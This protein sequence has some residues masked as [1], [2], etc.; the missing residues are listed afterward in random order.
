MQLCQFNIAIPVYKNLLL[1]FTKTDTYTMNTI[2]HLQMLNWVI[3][4]PIWRFFDTT[5]WLS[6]AVK[7]DGCDLPKI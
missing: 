7:A 6:I 2:T 3:L 5:A 1:K 4:M